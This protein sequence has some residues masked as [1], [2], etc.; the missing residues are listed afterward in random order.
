MSFARFPAFVLFLCLTCSFAR[1]ADINVVEAG[2]VPNSDSDCTAIFQK[3][4]D[5]CGDSGGGT[6][7]VP[8]GR[9]RIE[10]NLRVPSAVVLQGTFVAPP[11][12][13]GA[14]IGPPRLLRQ[15]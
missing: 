5:E 2:A 4:L 1:A 13:T 11:N 7:Y 10:G 6:V 14:R 12:A 3:C 15:G 9:Y 8:T